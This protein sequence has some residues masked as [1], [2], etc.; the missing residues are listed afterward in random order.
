MPAGAA[1]ELTAA[2][3][4]SG[5][6]E[7]IASGAL[8]DGA[9]KWRLRVASEGDL[10]VMGL[11]RSPMGHLSNLSRSRG[12]FGALPS[13]PPP[14]ASVVAEHAGGRRVR[15]EWS[16]VPGMRY[17]VELLLG[18]V[19]VEDR[20]LAATTRTD[21]RWSSLEPGTYSVRVRSVAADRTAGPWGE[22]SNEVVLD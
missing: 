1:V 20:S 13:L 17:G 12:A 21:F 5:D 3:L 16:E 15:A 9:G 14:P 6:S 22:P 19:P 11:L 7:A 10:A 18:G 8:G 4:E 2:E